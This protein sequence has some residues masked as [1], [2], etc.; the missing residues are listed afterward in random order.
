M[1]TTNLQEVQDYVIQHSNQQTKEFVDYVLSFYGV[2]EI[3]DMGATRE[4]VLQALAV[5]LLSTEA[6]NENGVFLK[7]IPFEGDSFDREY[8]RDIMVSSKGGK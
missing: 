7:D 4:D 8:I 2:G 6:K 3:Y 5:R 1:I